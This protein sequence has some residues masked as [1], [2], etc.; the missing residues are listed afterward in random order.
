MALFG[1]ESTDNCCKYALSLNRRPMTGRLSSAPTPEAQCAEANDRKHNSNE[2]IINVS[3]TVAELRL[4]ACISTLIALETTKQIVISQTTPVAGR[5]RRGLAAEAVEGERAVARLVASLT[6]RAVVGDGRV[7]DCTGVVQF[8]GC[9][10][11]YD[12]ETDDSQHKEYAPEERNGSRRA[13]SNKKTVLLLMLLLLLLLSLVLPLLL[14]LLLREGLL[15][16]RLLD[17][18]LQIVG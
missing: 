11:G 12:A 2:E 16:L 7:G 17:W 14:L 10:E 9:D 13:R 3:P 18:Q 4:P 6:T 1:T 8:V 15:C 5:V